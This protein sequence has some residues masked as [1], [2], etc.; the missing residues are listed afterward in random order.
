LISSQ[1]EISS[2]CLFDIY[3]MSKFI[4]PYFEIL[5]LKI[6]SNS[7]E[8]DDYNISIWKV[9]SGREGTWI[10]TRVSSITC[11]FMLCRCFEQFRNV[12]D[13]HWRFHLTKRT[14]SVFF[15][16]LFSCRF[17][18]ISRRGDVFVFEVSRRGCDVRRSFR[19]WREVFVWDIFIV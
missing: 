10:W 15:N 11:L 7:H 17:V 18:I 1:T 13:R 4:W 9:L 19:G 2:R 6:R 14:L 12:F 8:I 16:L 5:K 3:L